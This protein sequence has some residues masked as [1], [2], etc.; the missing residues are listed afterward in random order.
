M[1]AGVINPGEMFRLLDELILPGEEQALIAN[2]TDNT[3]Q[4]LLDIYVDRRLNSKT[5]G[6][7]YRTHLAF[8]AAGFV[9]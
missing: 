1:H 5:Y 6:T 2:M 9:A 7:N 4:L 3:K 8:C